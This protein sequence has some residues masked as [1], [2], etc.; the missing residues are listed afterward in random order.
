MPSGCRTV[1]WCAHHAVLIAAVRGWSNSSAFKQSLADAN[2]L[3]LKFISDSTASIAAWRSLVALLFLFAFN[4]WMKTLSR[5]AFLYLFVVVPSSFVVSTM[6]AKRIL[7][8]A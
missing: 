1:R 5:T 2:R 3:A 6:A 8:N 7:K 4:T